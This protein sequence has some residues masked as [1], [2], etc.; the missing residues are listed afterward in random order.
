MSQ[1]PSVTD[2]SAISEIRDL[3]RKRGE[4]LLQRKPELY[5]TFYWDDAKLFIFDHRMT[6]DEMRRRLPLLSAGSEAITVELPP[7]DDLAVSESG[8]AAT[9]SFQWS[10]RIR[11]SEGVVFDRVNYETDVWYRRN[12]IWRVICMHLTNLASDRVN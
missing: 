9:T 12:G 8:D 2:S 1:S 7:I 6:F 11:N 4:A 5:L 10:T 3:H